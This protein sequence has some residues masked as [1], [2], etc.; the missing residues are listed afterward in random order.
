[1]CD[2]NDDNRFAC[3]ICDDN[4]FACTNIGDDNRFVC[5][6][7][8]FDWKNFLDTC[9]SQERQSQ[10]YLSSVVN[11]LHGPIWRPSMTSAIPSHPFVSRYFF[12]SHRYFCRVGSLVAEFFLGLQ[13][14]V[15]CRQ[16]KRVVL[17]MSTIAVVSFVSSLPLF[18]NRM[19]MY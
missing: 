7:G 16:D 1:M 11:N 13:Y 14:G 3:T 8:S 19:S 18:V 12:M 9:P 5:A 17:V 6:I 10:A 4:R 15:F 2:R